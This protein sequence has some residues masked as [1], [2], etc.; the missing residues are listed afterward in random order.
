M[1]KI[2]LLATAMPAAILA[3]QAQGPQPTPQMMQELAAAFHRYYNQHR[4]ITDDAA[5]TQTRLALVRGVQQVLQSA[6]GLAGVTAPE[7]M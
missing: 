6:L 2:P 1:R 4:I 3:L 7:R 5:L